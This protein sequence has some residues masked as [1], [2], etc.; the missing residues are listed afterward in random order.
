MLVQRGKN[1]AIF[2]CIRTLIDNGALG[3]KTF[4]ILYNP[5]FYHLKFVYI[6]I[7]LL[8][9][10]LACNCHGHAS[11]CVYNQTVANSRLSLNSTGFY[12]GGGVCQNCTV[13]TFIR[14]LTFLPSL[15]I[16]LKI[17]DFE[18]KIILKLFLPNTRCKFALRSKKILNLF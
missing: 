17:F 7:L 6:L 16:F 1:I 5:F 8:L 10:H 14:I 13:H 4:L 18:P 12:S 9:F 3:I 2:I 15:N 11:S